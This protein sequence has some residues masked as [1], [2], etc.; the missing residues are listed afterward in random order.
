[1]L[2]FLLSIEEEELGDN[3]ADMTAC[4]TD[5]NLLWTPSLN[6]TPACI[7]TL[8]RFNEALQRFRI[9]PLSYKVL[10]RFIEA[11]SNLMRSWSSNRWRKMRSNRSVNGDA[12]L[13]QAATKL[14]KTCGSEFAALLWRHLTPQRK[15]AR[16]V[17]NYS[18]SGAQQPKNI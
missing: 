14:T 6:A 13:P 8:K 3:V 1:M 4:S 12:I 7:E 10:Q 11:P 15:T 18:P 17:H 9:Y 2:R 16:L 5:E